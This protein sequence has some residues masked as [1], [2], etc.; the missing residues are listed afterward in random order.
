[1]VAAHADSAGLGP[2]GLLK[3]RKDTGKVERRLVLGTKWPEYE[4]NET[5]TLL[6]FQA[7]EHEI[8]CYRF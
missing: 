1:M 5:G 3:V 6:F 7:D 4:T 8:D 2:P